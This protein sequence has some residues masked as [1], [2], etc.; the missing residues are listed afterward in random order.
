MMMPEPVQTDYKFVLISKLTAQ[1]ITKRPDHPIPCTK[2]LLKNKSVAL[3]CV[4]IQEMFPMDMD[5]G[6]LGFCISIYR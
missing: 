6:I 2:V 1:A 5:N 4:V 3:L